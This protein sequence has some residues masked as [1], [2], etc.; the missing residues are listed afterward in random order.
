VRWVFSFFLIAGQTLLAQ[1]DNALKIKL[2]FEKQ[3]YRSSEPR[4]AT[5]ELRNQSKATIRV[6]PRFDTVGGPDGGTYFNLVRHPKPLRGTRTVTVQ[7]VL[8]ETH[9]R[10]DI[11][12]EI[13]CE[14]IRLLPGSTYS[15]R[16]PMDDSLIT[17][18]AYSYSVTFSSPQLY[19]DERQ[20]IAERGM[21]AFIGSVTSNVA[22][23]RIV[24]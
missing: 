14:W 7:H 21:N 13:A 8:P 9:R 11:L 19:P 16:I 15:F 5:V 22:T 17:P 6:A 2:R 10:R 12:S 3:V 18:G 23:F 1:S 24:K 20:R 4:F